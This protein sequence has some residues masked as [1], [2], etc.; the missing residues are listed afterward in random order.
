MEKS[1]AQNF[2]VNTHLN[3]FQSALCPHCCLGKS[4]SLGPRVDIRAWKATD[5]FAKKG[6]ANQW[7]ATAGPPDLS[8]VIATQD[9]FTASCHSHVYSSCKDRSLLVAFPQNLQS[10]GHL[11]S[12]LPHLDVICLI[13]PPPLPCPAPIGCPTSTLA[14]ALCFGPLCPWH[15]TVWAN[16]AT[17]GLSWWA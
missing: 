1:R 15:F 17:K 8:P 12:A 9:I 4:P 14:S 13:S 5:P 7:Q 16:T 10:N 3:F 11:N 2:F 6:S